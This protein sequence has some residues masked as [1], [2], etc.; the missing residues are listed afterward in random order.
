[1]DVYYSFINDHKEG[2]A[3]G[4]PNEEGYQGPPDSPEI[5]EIIDNSDEETAANSPDQYIGA[6][7]GLPDRKG[8]KL[9]GEIS[10]IARYDY[11]STDEVHYNAMHVNSLYEV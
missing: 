8:D 5:D 7:V 11:T 1:M 3:K 10:K 6:E 9:M 2:I 4:D